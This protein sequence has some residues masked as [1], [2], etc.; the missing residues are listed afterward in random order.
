MSTDDSDNEYYE[1]LAHGRAAQNFSTGETIFRQGDPGESMFIVREG[2]VELTDGERLIET[3]EPPGLFGEMALIEYEP[4]SLTATAATDVTVVELP[5]RHFW[6]L[7]H[8]TPYFA[9][10]VMTVMARRLRQR[11]ATA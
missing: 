11:S 4:R 9:R 8:E 1:L 2:A 10:L 7:V 5:V 3:V 6:V